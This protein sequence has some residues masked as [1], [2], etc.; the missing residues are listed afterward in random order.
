MKHI[1]KFQYSSN[2]GCLYCKKDNIM[3]LCEKILLKL[4]S[5]KRLY[6]NNLWN[7]SEKAVATAINIER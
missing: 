1:I 3:L 2:L 4:A 5:D 6:R 7:N